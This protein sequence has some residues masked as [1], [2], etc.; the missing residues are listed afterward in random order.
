MRNPFPYRRNAPQIVISL[1]LLLL[2]LSFMFFAPQTFL[3]SRIY[4]A[5]LSTI[6]FVGLIAIA[7]T[8]VIVTGEID[9]SFPA[10]MAAA[11]FAFS[12]TYI[13]TSSPMLGLL[14]ALTI[15]L[16]AG[17]FNAL[18]VVRL[19]VPAIIATIGTQFFWRGITVLMAGGLA[20]NMPKLRGTPLH[21]LFVGRF[22]EWL[23]AQSLWL[24]LIGVLSWLIYRGHI[25]GDNIRFC[26]DNS[27]AAKMMGIP[28]TATRVGVFV[29]M[30]LITSLTGA[31]VCMEMASW[32]PTQGEGYMLLS[33]AAVFIGGTSVYGGTGSIYGSV[34]GAIIIGIIEAG[35]ISCG[36]SGLWTRMIYGIIIIIAVSLHA[37]LI[38]NSQ[39]S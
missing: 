7:M 28:V 20:I 34:I 15:G 3:H 12:K 35:I 2:I 39:D 36:L 11:G 18:L 25:W 8:F 4:I 1:V 19:H 23:P 32:W 26:G 38:K 5:Y 31:M 27:A 9:L 17:L 30:G 24:L 37:I 21:H 6:P 13:L 10:V 22:W 33:F 16:M 29:L 14:C